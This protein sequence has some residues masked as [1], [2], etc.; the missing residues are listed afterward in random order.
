MTGGGDDGEAL[1]LLQAQGVRLVT[2]PTSGSMVPELIAGRELF[3]G[4]D[5]IRAYLR[6]LSR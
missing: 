5:E 3:R 1:E 2:I 6:R 4:L